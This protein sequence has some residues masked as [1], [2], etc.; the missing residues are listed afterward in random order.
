MQPNFV[1]AAVPALE[2]VADGLVLAR[3]LS[4]R[5]GSNIDRGHQ[6]TDFASI[7]FASVSGQ[8]FGRQSY[9]A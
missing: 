2:K 8:I 6:L 3:R 4:V 1:R 5:Q 9:S 7:V